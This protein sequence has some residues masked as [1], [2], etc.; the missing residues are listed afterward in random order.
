MCNCIEKMNAALKEH[1]GKIAETLLLP[2]PGGNALRARSLVQTRKL[3][4][5][6]RK[7]VPSVIASHCPFCGREYADKCNEAGMSKRS[8]HGLCTHSDG[9]PDDSE[10]AALGMPVNVGEEA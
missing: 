10:V 9:A 5:T 3:D 7:A 8:K 4:D 6:K 1:N 2:E